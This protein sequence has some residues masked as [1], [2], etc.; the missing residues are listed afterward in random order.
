MEGPKVR[1]EAQERGGVEIERDSWTA[2]TA[3]TIWR[4][5]SVAISGGRRGEGR[6]GERERGR[7]GSSYRSRAIVEPARYPA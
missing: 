3:T 2:V 7:G 1:F 6:G 4:N 5:G